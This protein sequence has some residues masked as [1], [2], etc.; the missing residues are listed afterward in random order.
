MKK[1]SLLLC[2]L[3]FLIAFS[4]RFYDCTS[5]SVKFMDESGHVSASVHYWNSGQFEPDHWEHP[6]LRPIILY[7]F[8]QA[9][10]DNPYGWRMRN[11]LFGAVAASLTFLFALNISNCR[12]TALLAGLLMATDPLHIVLSRFTF[13]EVYSAAFFLAAV[14]L[15]LYHDRR[16]TWL[17]L[18]AFFI[19]C[20]IA[21]KWYYFPGWLLIILLALH[22]NRSYRD[23]RST[24]FISCTYIF[25]PLTVYTLAFSFWFGRG[26]SVS[27]FVEFVTN[28]FYS[29][30]Q[31]KAENYMAGLVFLSHLSAGEWF[32]RPIV[33]G[34]GTYLD[35]GKGE[36]ILFI[37]NLPIWILT[38]PS[39]VGISVL[40]VR[41][42]CLKTALPALLF[43]GSYMLYL[44][45]KRPAF[46]YSVVPLLPYAFT[47]IAYAITQLV[48]RYSSRI[49]PAAL[50]VS[51]GWNLFLYP[52]VTYKKISIA[53]YRYILN[54]KDIQAR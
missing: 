33:V 51:L 5:P 44:F 42:R 8:L 50:V 9:F 7:G 11:I 52:L 47:L 32:I 54:S 35:A 14:V 21:T 6:P 13:C 49:Y 28:V 15:Y 4:L 34:Q 39:L 16:S 17:M 10:G 18:S 46:L 37:N 48:G 31:Y 40:A 19:G 12:K 29:I 24:L 25:I 45:V 23:P 27:E 20:A 2:C 1:Y 41:E 3:V 38:I 26:Y 22:E 43:C 36:F 53:S 30:Q